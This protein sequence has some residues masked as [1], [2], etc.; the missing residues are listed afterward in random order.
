M[1]TTYRMILMAAFCAL[2]GT[3]FS[4]LAGQRVGGG[5]EYDA[6]TGDGDNGMGGYGFYEIDLSGPISAQIEAN[7]VTGDFEVDAGSG[8][9]T[10]I[11]VGGALIFS[12]AMDNLTP[13]F[14][15]GAADNFNDYNFDDRPGIVSYDDK[16]SIFW[17]IGT[18]LA[19]NDAAAFDISVRYRGL[20]PDSRDVN[21]GEIDMDAIVVRA[22]LVFD[23]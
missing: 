11:G 5:Y 14:G 10:M 19:I 2:I 8:D 9:Y 23:L 16:L 3:S 7:Y 21:V 15:A 13:Y 1:R 17:L 20:R 12:H 18:R 4:S 22:G 6:V